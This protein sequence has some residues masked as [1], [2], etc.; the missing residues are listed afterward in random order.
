MIRGKLQSTDTG[1]GS[2]IS[3]LT[4]PNFQNADTD[5]RF[6]EGY[7]TNFSAQKREYVLLDG[8]A[9]DWE[10]GMGYQN[11]TNFFRAHIIESTNADAA[12]NLSVGTHTI[13]FP[14]GGL[15]S[16]FA[17]ARFTGTASP[18]GGGGAN[19][20]FTGFHENVDNV[21]DLPGNVVPTFNTSQ[22]LGNN[23]YYFKALK[24][25]MLVS[26]STA[27]PGWLKITGINN[28]I[29]AQPGLVGMLPT[30]VGTF[31]TTISSPLMCYNPPIGT[32]P[33]YGG[34]S[35]DWTFS[36]TNT[37]TAAQTVTTRMTVDYYL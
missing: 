22:P 33:D 5:S 2:P 20:T 24:V 32:S 16:R 7:F 10:Y 14:A 23:V 8:N 21:Y 4:V 31:N 9:T 19:F 11:G 30:D 28:N 29:Y 17:S 37:G 35:W 3:V 13:L 34:N 12:I 15:A 1:A 6:T 36:V 27:Q 25:H 18:A 26:F